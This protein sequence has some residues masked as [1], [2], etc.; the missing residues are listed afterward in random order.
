M[1]FESLLGD[2]SI[3]SCKETIKYFSEILHSYFED[4]SPNYFSNEGCVFGYIN[5]SNGLFYCVIDNNSIPLPLYYSTVFR[6]DFENIEKGVQLNSYL[7]NIWSN[8]N[9]HAE[10]G[11]FVPVY[12][13]DNRICFLYCKTFRKYL[14]KE[15]SLV[16]YSE[17]INSYPLLFSIVEHL[18]FSA[19]H[20]H[21]LQPKS[22]MMMR[23]IEKVLK[24]GNYPNIQ[25]IN[26]LANMKY[27]NRNNEGIICFTN[28][29]EKPKIK[30]ITPQP[31]VQEEIRTLRKYSQM[32][33]DNFCLI[34]ERY[35][36]I[37]ADP[38][39]NPEV[40]VWMI[41][42][43]GECKNNMARLSFSTGKKWKLVLNNEEFGFDGNQYYARNHLNGKEKLGVSENQF[44]A[45]K[46]LDKKGE[47]LKG[48]E[49]LCSD[50]AVKKFTG[51]VKKLINQKHGTMLMISSHARGEASRLGEQRRAIETEAFELSSLTDKEMLMISSIDGCILSD[52]NG[53]C[54]ALGVILDGDANIAT[55]IGRGAR[56]NSALTYINKMKEEE[57]RAAAI[58]ISEDGIVD[59]IQTKTICEKQSYLDKMRCVELA[60]E[61]DWQEYRWDMRL[62]EDDDDSTT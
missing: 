28:T 9:E 56:Y 35:D 45:T 29:K 47:L 8:M 11:L 17:F 12:L 25:F 59:V 5:N 18:T 34:A 48:L 20:S 60:A 61:Q 39:Y 42:G 40:D 19:F 26:S 22:T 3:Y 14:L 6:T 32:T 13:K 7:E 50:T 43:I 21:K 31:L 27:E 41:Q 44:H 23:I 15:K 37:F 4:D 49:F 58:V 2:L 33:G 53:K 24:N 30:F 55:D 54:V 16:S 38:R 51:I 10:N 62:V 36:F 1:S 57:I 46:P 52:T